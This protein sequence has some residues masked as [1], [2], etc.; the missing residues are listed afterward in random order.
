MDTQPVPHRIEEWIHTYSDTF[1][2]YLCK[3]VADK[4]NAKDILQETF[5]AAWKSSNSFRMEADEKTWL[6]SILRHK[7]MDYYRRQ[8][9]GKKQSARGEFFF[10]DAGHWKEDTAPGQ[11]PQADEALQR[12]EFFGVLQ[13]CKSKL[14]SQQQLAFTMKYLDDE[15]ATTICK[16]LAITTSNYW[17]LLHRCKLQLRQCLEKNWFTDPKK[18]RL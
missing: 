12:K 4:D 11:W 13:Q 3:R 6:F 10:D 5:I 15:D 1:F 8:A 14:T 16:V 18:E 7:L 2:D 9:K 17:V